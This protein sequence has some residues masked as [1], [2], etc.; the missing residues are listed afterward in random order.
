MKRSLLLGAALCFGVA[1]IAQTGIMKEVGYRY[2]SPRNSIDPVQVT[3]VLPKAVK[4]NWDGTSEV[5][6]T[7]ITKS[8]NIY[9]ALV[10]EQTCI[11]YNAATNSILFASRGGT[12]AA[13]TGN[14]I[15]ASVSND[16]G[17]SFNSFIAAQS[18][19]SNLLRYPSGAIYNPAGN[20][21]PDQAYFSVSGPVT[22][23]SVWTGTFFGMGTLSGQNLSLTSIDKTGNG[24]LLLRGG[25][26]IDGQGIGHIAGMQ[27]VG[28]SGITEYKA[29]VFRGVF[30][31]GNNTMNWASVDMMPGVVKGTDGIYAMA[32]QM[33]NVAFSPDGSVGYLMYVGSDNRAPQNDLC[34]YQPIVYKTTDGGATW[35]QMAYIDLKNNAVMS[36]YLFGLRRDNGT[37][38]PHF[39]EADL[40]VDS[41]GDLHI[42]ASVAGT[43]SDHI[44]SVGRFIFKYEKGAIFELTNVDQSDTWYVNYVDTLATRE[45]KAE[46]GGYGQGTDAA[47]WSHRVQAS[48]SAD[49]NRVF[50]TWTDTDPVFWGFQTIDDYFNRYPDIKGWGRDI[51]N[52]KRTLAKNFTNTSDFAGDN[53]FN[54]AGEVARTIDGGNEI[55]YTTTVIDF[56]GGPGAA[57]THFYVNGIQFNDNDFVI[58][59]VKE[60]SSVVNSIDVYPNPAKDQATIKMNLA[61]GGNAEI[62]L[63]NITGQKVYSQ[64]IEAQQG[65]QQITLPVANLNSGVY[66]YSVTINGERVSRKLVVE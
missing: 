44:D 13:G 46:E 20:T 2:A 7:E 14:D 28:S 38:K 23:S 58:T 21:S 31:G 60:N 3:N 40:V 57:V 4:H 53:F 54:Y 61:K 12:G 29:V 33:N 65:A 50:V 18:A 10:E 45:V 5:G 16:G 51:T 52:N 19:N 62:A 66:F 32:Y 17:I 22:R 30:D 47:G 63:Y 9:T 8:I 34:G 56:A 48:R 39:N 49:G 55:A 1:S 6:R 26:T 35:N 11:S 15:V 27:Y 25:M 24:D 37:V 64:N 36:D 59:G 43:Y 41:K 42:F